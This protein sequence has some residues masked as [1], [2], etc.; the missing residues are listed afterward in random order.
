MPE[1][2]VDEAQRLAR[3]FL[4]GKAGDNEI[5]QLQGALADD[6]GAALELLSQ[7]QSA[8]DDS[9]PA[10]L[11]A[12]QE[13]SVA[14]R[15]EA[16][17]APRVRKRSLLGFFKK[18]FRGSP[19]AAE[20]PAPSKSRRRRGGSAEAPAPAPSDT[21]PDDA[22]SDTLPGATGDGM[23]EMA[24][25]A[26]GGGSSAADEGGDGST[27]SLPAKPA[28]K[29]SGGW[30]WVLVG[31][32]GSLLLLGLLGAGVAFWFHAKSKRARPMPAAVTH[33]ATAPGGDG[34]PPVALSPSAAA[35][36][37]PVAPTA[38]PTATP[39][40]SVH[41]GISIAPQNSDGSEALPAQIPAT[42]PVSAG[43]W[44]Q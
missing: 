40:G 5:Q 32:L 20:E 27:V 19:K 26:A 37:P 24:P 3:L 2:S 8:L 22:L 25:I 14:S 30:I 12:E 41:R 21:P 28:K 13:R 7:M 44:P 43:S 6:Q 15:I 17:I 16:L 10:G 33:P 23:E 36:K 31:L 11:N 18:I 34:S 42:T 38:V 4:T 1:L 39:M 29:K 9:A 35:P